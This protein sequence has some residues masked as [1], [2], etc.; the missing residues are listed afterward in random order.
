LDKYNVRIVKGLDYREDINSEIEYRLR[1][2][3]GDVTTDISVVP[4]IP[5]GRT[6]KTRQFISNLSTD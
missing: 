2:V 4:Y 6:G 3:L 5:K 1:N